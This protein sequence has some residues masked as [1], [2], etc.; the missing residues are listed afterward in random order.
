LAVALERQAHTW[1][2]KLL[3]VN[4]EFQVFE[5]DLENILVGGGKKVGGIGLEPTT[6]S[7]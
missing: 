1:R 7:V 6:S 2:V 5:P 4:I 3:L